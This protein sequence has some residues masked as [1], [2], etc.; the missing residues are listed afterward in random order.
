MPWLLGRLPEDYFLR[1]RRERLAGSYG[2]TALWLARNALGALLILVGVAM[3]VLPG[4]G[5]VTI[6]AGIVVA[7]VPGKRRLA[8]WVLRRRGVST[9]VDWL[10]A[11]NGKP[12]LLLP[13]PGAPPPSAPQ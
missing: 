7:D 10:R 12:P 11:R 5:L 8:L 13:A 2:K 3:L 1:T 4:Q 9:A 6:L